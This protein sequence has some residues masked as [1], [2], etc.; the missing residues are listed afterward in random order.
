MEKMEY[1]NE[2]T[3]D[4]E[5]LYGLSADVGKPERLESMSEADLEALLAKRINTMIRDDFAGLVQL[6]YRIDVNE[7]R[8]RQLLRSKP[9]EDAGKLIAPLIIERQC[10]KI[11]TRRQYSKERPGGENTGRPQWEE[12]PRWEEV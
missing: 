4:L 11:V 9:R 7:V 5:R 2:L 1:W 3:Q 12:G 6:L 10:Q 8:L